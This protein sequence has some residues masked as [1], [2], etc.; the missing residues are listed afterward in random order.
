MLQMQRLPCCLVVI[1]STA[2]IGPAQTVRLQPALSPV[3]NPLKGLVPYA[4]PN[5][6]ADPPPR[7]IAHSPLR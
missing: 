6:A 5:P 7:T 4:D 2:S 1:P 3:D